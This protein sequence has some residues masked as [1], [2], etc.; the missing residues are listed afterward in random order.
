M[1]APP[2]TTAPECVHALLRAR[3]R[4]KQD[5]NL[6]AARGLGLAVDILRRRMGVPA[7]PEP[8]TAK[9]L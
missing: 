4:Y 9:V 8:P 2:I 3:S 5:G 6:V 1:S 7:Q